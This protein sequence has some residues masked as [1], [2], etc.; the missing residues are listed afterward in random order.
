MIFFLLYKKWHSKRITVNKPLPTT[1]ESFYK[2]T[3]CEAP[4][5]NIFDQSM[6]FKLIPNTFWMD[7]KFCD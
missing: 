2:Y 5:P 3:N 6:I 4:E 1:K 7:D